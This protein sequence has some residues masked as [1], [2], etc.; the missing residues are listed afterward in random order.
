MLCLHWVSTDT[1]WYCFV[2]KHCIE[3]EKDFPLGNLE[4]YEKIITP[5]YGMN[6]KYGDPTGTGI[7]IWDCGR[8]HASLYWVSTEP[9]GLHS[10]QKRRTVTNKSTQKQRCHSLRM[11][12]DKNRV[13]GGRQDECQEVLGHLR[14]EPNRAKEQFLNEWGIPSTKA[15]PRR[16]QSKARNE[17]NK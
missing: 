14:L 1:G 3:D 6:H 5:Q 2:T 9:T 7:A 17:M 10:E 15:S 11:L 4:P 12:S 13:D 8:Y 16:K